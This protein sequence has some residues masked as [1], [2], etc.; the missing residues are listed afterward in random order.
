MHDKVAKTALDAPRMPAAPSSGFVLTR[1]GSADA[2]RWKPG[3]RLDRLFADVARKW[4]EQTAVEES[5]GRRMTFAEL[6]AAATRLAAHLVRSGV[7]PGARVGILLDNGCDSY[8]AMLAVMRAGAAFV[9]LDLGFPDDRIAFIL[10]DAEVEAVITLA[11][12]GGRLP[13]T[14]PLVIALDDPRVMAAEPLAAV[15]VETGTDDALC[16]VIYTSGTTGRPKG[17]QIDHSNICNFVLVACETYGIPPK[18]RMYQGL[19]IAFDFA[20]EEIWVPLFGGAVLV[21]SPPGQK[22]VGEELH[23]FLLEHRVTALCAVPTLLATV[24]KD[25]P[26]LSFLLVS[27]EACPPDLIARWWRPDRRFLNAYGP[28]EATV[29]ATISVVEEVGP[30]TIGRP[31]PTYRVVILAP[32]EARALERGDTG[33]V[34]LA[35]PGLSRG[36]LNRP[37]LTARAFVPD[38]LGLPDNPTGTLY[39]TGDL[40]RINEAG[41]IEY[42]GRIDTQVKIRGYRIELTEIESVILSAPGIAQA[43]VEPWK[44]APDM[45]DLVAYYTLA[46]DAEVDPEQIQKLL[47]AKLPPYMVPAYFERLDQIP[48][49]PSDKADRKALPAPRSERFSAS[50]TAYVA[51]EGEMETRIATLIGEMLGL[52][53]VSVTAHLFEEIGANSLTITRLAARIRGEMPDLSISARDAYQNPTIRRFAAAILRAGSRQAKAGA[54][55]PP[56]RASRWA[57]YGTGAAQVLA[58]LGWLF[59]YALAFVEAVDFVDAAETTADT[60]MRAIMVGPVAMIV[61]CGLPV[62]GKWL[63]IGRWRAERFPIWGLRYFRFWLV[64]A[65]TRASPLAFTAGTPLFVF[66]LRLLGAR[67]GRNVVIQDTRLPV[68]TDLLVVGDDTVIAKDAW[69]CGYRAENGGIETGPV[70]LGR[71]CRVGENAVLDIDVAIGDGGELSPASTLIRGQRVP[72]GEAWHGNP[73]RRGPPAARPISVHAP[74]RERALAFAVAQLAFQWLLMTPLALWA[75]VEIHRLGGGT[76]FDPF[77]ASENILIESIVLYFAGMLTLIGVVVIVPRLAWL[78]LE[79]RRDYPLYGFA[80]FLYRIVSRRSNSRVLNILFGD[81]SYILHYLRAVGF[82]IS[83]SGQTGSNFGLVQ[84][85]DVPFAT[86]VGDGT[87]VSDG[88]TIANTAYTPGSFQVERVRIGA[89]NFIGNQVLFPAGARTGD[90]CLIATKAAIPRTGPLREN[91][92]LLGS[93]AIEIPRSVRRD[94]ALDIHL[95][96][97]LFERRLAL[98]NRSNLVTIALFL[99]SRSLLFSIVM[100]ISSFAFDLHGTAG[101]V[102]LAASMLVVTA[103]VMVYLVLVERL[104]LGFGRLK[105]RTCSIY[106]PYYWS[107]ERY[108]KLND[109]T[110]IQLLNG[111]PFK[112][113]VWRLL[114]VRWGRMN[115]DDGCAVTERTL[116]VVGDHNTFGD[117]SVLQSHSLEDGV[118][119]S[120]FV[121][122]G[123][124]CTVCAKAYV[125]YGVTIGDGALVD[126]DAFVLKGESLAAGSVW[127]GNPAQDV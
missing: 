24:E 42:L 87:M 71:G 75:L 79:E 78:A 3:M 95:V 70:E 21:P 116:L 102:A 89:S 35:G 55:K 100:A 124:G 30:V 44:P 91:T 107:H 13:P 64:R 114:G 83:R 80:Y 90:D 18:A 4:A 36:Y 115:F 120:D 33:E 97:G 82:R 119:K 32:G 67:I 9:P 16:Y 113:L 52:R 65:L 22:L 56:L 92:G 11:S 101:A 122:V 125:S 38:F 106:D 112:G 74:S 53:D 31:L 86:E 94:K 104:T 76:S 51:P 69:F 111:T 15:T 126:T 48:M 26:L 28:T 93:P 118:F 41:E 27:G 50:A 19:T 105:P 23:A 58:Y 127:R 43:V 17:V 7:R 96:P 99:F 110:L 62:L 103:V 25:V 77:G 46:R 123:D 68:A 66:Y 73:G 39:R 14:L 121:T 84:R 10:E 117:M 61:T 29:T 59:F 81:S 1:P 37:D 72:G 57:F 54:T 45:V 5:D 63:L 20:V 108:W 47:K 88:F 109:A 8:V 12:R 49:L 40:G 85:H 34:A 60:V 98:K 2:S 6:D